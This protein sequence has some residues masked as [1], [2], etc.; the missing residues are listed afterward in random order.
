MAGPISP[1]YGGRISTAQVSY[2]LDFRIFGTFFIISKK[3]I[4]IGESPEAK[5]IEKTLLQ[6]YDFSQNIFA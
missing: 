2:D 3:Y 6:E 5:Q 4:I 1:P